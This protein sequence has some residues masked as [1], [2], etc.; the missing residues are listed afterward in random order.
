VP[1]GQ[2]PTGPTMRAAQSKERGRTWEG[3]MARSPR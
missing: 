2:I 1:A 3:S